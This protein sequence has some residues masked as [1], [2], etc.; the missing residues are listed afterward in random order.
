[1]PEVTDIRLSMVLTR[2]MCGLWDRTRALKIGEFVGP[3]T[4]HF[5]AFFL[6]KMSADP[7]GE[8]L[9]RQ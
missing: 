5:I 2:N 7:G 1:M 9:A 8:T 6:C 3:V 4:V